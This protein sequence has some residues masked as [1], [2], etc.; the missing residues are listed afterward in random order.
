[1]RKSEKKKCNFPECDK[2]VKARGLCSTHYN[3]LPEN[4]SKRKARL[5]LVESFPETKGKRSRRF[6]TWKSKVKGTIEYHSKR[7][8]SRVK[9]R[10][11]KVGLEFN[12]T[13]EDIVIPEM[14]PVLNI[15]ID[16]LA[17]KVE[18]NSASLDRIDSSKGYIKG[19]VVVISWEANNIKNDATL[20]ELEKIAKWMSKQDK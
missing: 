9:A 5:K 14:C 3:Q 13:L 16:L 7:M 4:K 19:N 15:P 10:A 17:S 6:K 18:S 11:K 8:L 1:M 2:E 20:E 12:L